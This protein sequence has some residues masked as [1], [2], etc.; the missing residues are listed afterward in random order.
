MKT[1]SHVQYLSFYLTF[2]LFAIWQ[3]IELQCCFYRTRPNNLQ[4]HWYCISLSTI[5][6]ADQQ[7]RWRRTYSELEGWSWDVHF[8]VLDRDSVDTQLLGHKVDTIQPIFNF[9]N[10][11]CLSHT[12]GGGHC[13]SQVERW[14]ARQLDGQPALWPNL[15]KWHCF[16]LTLNAFCL[17]VGSLT[18]NLSTQE[19]TYWLNKYILNFVL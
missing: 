16:S 15:S 12:P 2:I 18:C 13:G 3:Q 9:T 14:D 17:S 8:L 6:L 7:I 10:L 11:S 19:W 5:G 4:C 1:S